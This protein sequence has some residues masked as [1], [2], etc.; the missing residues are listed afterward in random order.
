MQTVELKAIGTLRTTVQRLLNDFEHEDEVNEIKNFSQKD[1]E[2]KH[3]ALKR[4][5]AVV[6][7]SE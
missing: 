5:I 1:K 6:N 3:E 7:E 2:S 4:L